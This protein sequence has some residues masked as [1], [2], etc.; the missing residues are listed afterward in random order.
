MHE[1]RNGP[2]RLGHVGWAFAV[3]WV[4]VGLIPSSASAEDFPISVGI[5]APPVV[6]PSLVI[7]YPAPAQ[8]LITLT[9]THERASMAHVVTRLGVTGKRRLPSQSMGSINATPYLGLG[10]EL[11]W[12]TV[13]VSDAT[14]TTLLLQSRLI[15]G[16]EHELARVPMILFAEARHNFAIQPV[17]LGW[18]ATIGVRLQL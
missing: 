17:G 3:A 11:G 18:G 13:H 15:V 7:A 16:A 2:F 10:F 1:S 14:S 5:Q 4:L 9:A 8:N 12:I 6:L